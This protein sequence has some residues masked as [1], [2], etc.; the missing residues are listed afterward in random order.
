MKS[1]PIR[2]TGTSYAVLA[3]FD[4]CGGEATSYDLK[5]A[6]EVSVQNFWPVPHTTAYEEPARLAA[7]GYLT[8]RQES[9]GR[10][11]R[12]YSL[13]DSG[14]AALRAWTA[15]PAVAPPQLRE[16][17]V[18]KIFAGAEPGPLLDARLAWHRG[19]R[20]ELQS[21]LEG[22][23]AAEGMENAERT[24]VIGIVYHEKML[25]LL[26]T[27]AGFATVSAGSVGD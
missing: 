7:A 4:Q 24:L 3:L 12:V 5:Q 21:L 18:L 22:I 2:L 1:K 11:K 9:G 19:K 8:A 16:E 26:E 15:D 6:L 25:E 13:T 17:A 27:M 14:R 23:Q 10:R 20:E